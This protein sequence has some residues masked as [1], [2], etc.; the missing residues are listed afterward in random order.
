MVEKTELM[1][2]VFLF[3]LVAEEEVLVAEMDP[4]A[5]RSRVKVV[6]LVVE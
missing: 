1:V 4:G 5:V 3:Q 2:P 6:V